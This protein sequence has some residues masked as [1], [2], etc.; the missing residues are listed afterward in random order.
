MPLLRVSN[1]ETAHLRAVS[2]APGLSLKGGGMKKSSAWKM[3]CI[4]CMFCAAAVI[5]S[6]AQTFTTLVNFA[7]ANGAQPQASLIQ[8]TDGNFYGTTEAGGTSG[9]C[10]GGC[11]TVFK[12]TAGGTLTTL[13]SFDGTD[14]AY[15]SA[16]LV[17]ATDG[18]FYGTTGDRGASG[19]CPPFGCGTVFK[20]TPGGTLTTLHSFDGTDGAYPSAGLVQATDGNFYGTTEGG[21]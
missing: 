1:Q 20:I 15:P 6:P 4:V 11:G 17:Q 16:G 21:G 5:A 13:H 14:G 18:N 3:A 12:I 9:N 2:L 7:G 10:S 8:G 19:N